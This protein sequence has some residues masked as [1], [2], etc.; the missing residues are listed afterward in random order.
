MNSLFAFTLGV[1]LQLV[2][3]KP[4]DTTTPEA[5]DAICSNEAQAHLCTIAS[6]VSGVVG[7]AS[8]LPFN[9]PA[10]YEASAMV[11]VSI[12]NHESH[13]R[14]GIYDCSLCDGK[15][16]RCDHGRSV[17]IYQMQ[18]SAWQGFDRQSV[19]EDDFIA[20]YLAFRWYLK[21]AS[22]SPKSSFRGYAGCQLDLDCKGADG[23]TADFEKVL[24]KAH[25]FLNGRYATYLKLPPPA[26]VSTAELLS[27]R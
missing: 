24:R 1:I 19:C 14:S 18:R 22:P 27:S 13:F 2:T 6:D 5:V 15:T 20:S 21:F 3:F 10:K 8:R 17:S 26:A 4:V 7:Q 25:L 12:A 11:L 16:A 9:G 23:I